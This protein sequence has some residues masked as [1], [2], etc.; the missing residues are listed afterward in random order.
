MPTAR[1]LGIIRVL[2]SG[3]PGH[4]ASSMASL[5]NSGPRAAILPYAGTIFLSAS[6][7]CA[8]DPRGKRESVHHSENRLA[9][10]KGLA[11]RYFAN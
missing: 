11:T 2:R 10:A 8:A 7:L 3:G 5:A 6:Q 9:L 4:H 1:R